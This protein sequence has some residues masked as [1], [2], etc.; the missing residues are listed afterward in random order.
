MENQ[1]VTIIRPAPTIPE[2]PRMPYV[3][4]SC[5]MSLDGYLDDATG[6][7]LILSNDEDWDRVDALRASAD[8]ILVGAGTLRTDNPRLQVRSV[9]RRADRVRARQSATPLRVVVSARGDLDPTMAFFESGARDSLVYTDDGAVAG[10]RARLGRIAS[11]IGAGAP[12]DLRDV[13]ADL[14]MHG[15]DRLVVE[16]GGTMHT[17]FLAQGL[18]DELQLIIAPFF[19][20]DSRAPRF[21][22]PGHFANDPEHPLLLAET[23]P[24]GDLIYARYLATPLAD[25]PGF[26]PGH[27]RSTPGPRR[28]TKKGTRT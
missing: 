23:R 1:Q 27:R 28:R 26:H 21:V 25:P 10:A 12:L 16:G 22:G 7:R 3:V 11:V 4:L 24:I 15:V 6:S 20:G 14:A 18:A 8:A 19:V 2:R 9:D 13:L 5:A 17:Q